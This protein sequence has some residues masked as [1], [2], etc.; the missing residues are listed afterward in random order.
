MTQIVDVTEL[1]S[2][3]MVDQIRNDLE[4]LRLAAYD[5][6]SETTDGETG[7]AG[8]IEFVEFWQLVVDIEAQL[9]ASKYFKAGI[10]PS[11]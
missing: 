11:R 6:H 5:V 4:N 8:E 7:E 1:E 9:E 3:P 10:V 2:L